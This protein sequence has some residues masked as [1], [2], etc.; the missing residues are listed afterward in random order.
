VFFLH[1]L[2]LL[3]THYQYNFNFQQRVELELAELVQRP[4]AGSAIT[5]RKEWFFH[6][7]HFP[8]HLMMLFTP[9]TCHRY[10]DLVK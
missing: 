3:G 1:F 7:N 8:S 4:L 6:L 9:L 10:W 2:I 5:G